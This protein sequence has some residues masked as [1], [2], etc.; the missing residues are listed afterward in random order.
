MEKKIIKKGERDD[1]SIKVKLETK[2]VVIHRPP[3]CN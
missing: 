1:L 2:V 3:T